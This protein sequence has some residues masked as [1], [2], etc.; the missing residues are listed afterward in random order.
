LH[1]YPL[2][3]IKGTNPSFFY[4][5]KE[6]SHKGHQLYVIT[7][8]ETRPRSCQLEFKHCP[9]NF[10]FSRTN[11]WDKWCKSILFILLAPVKVWFLKQSFKIDFVYCDDSFPFYA[12]LVKKITCLPTIMRLGDLQTAYMFY[13]QGPLA[14]LCYSLFHSIETY[15]WKKIDKIICIS[16]SFKRFLLKEGIKEGKVFVVEESIDIDEFPKGA[17]GDT[18]RRKNNL[19]N[20]PILMFH[21]LVSRI[22]GVEILLKALPLVLEAVPQLKL[23]IVGDGPELKRLKCL[24]R[25]LAISHSVIFTGWVPLEEVP[26]YIA[27]CDIGIPIR[28]NNL[29]NNFIVTTAFL[30]YAVL[31][32]PVVVPSLA[33]FEDTLRHNQRQLIF[34]LNKIESLAQSI[35][36][37]LGNKELAEQIALNNYQMVQEI[38]SAKV[39]AKRLAA[40]CLLNN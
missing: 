9:L 37:L 19:T 2:S 15:I 5:L 36:S 14:R 4:F 23:M 28:S 21:G 32:R 12:Y 39:I 40:V 10:V 17:S 1:R 33:S 20:E 11:D 18:V 26:N 24:A 6:L 7:F 16:E 30:Q 31:K 22:K 13:G 29:G 34:S 8:K 27:A 38:Y 3:E 25:E 35:I